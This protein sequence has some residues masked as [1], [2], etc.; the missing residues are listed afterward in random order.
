MSTLF[1]LADRNRICLNGRTPNDVQAGQWLTSFS[2][3]GDAHLRR[4]VNKFQRPSILQLNIEGLTASKMSVLHHLALQCEAL[5]ILL[6]ETHCTSVERLDIPSYH[7]AGFSLSRKHGLATFVHERLKWILIDQSPPTSE[8]EWV[9]VDVDNYKIVNMVRMIMELI[10]NRSFTLTTGDSK[11]SRLRRL[12]N[13]VLQGSVLA[14]LFFNI[15]TYD[16]P[17]ITSKKFAYADDL[18]ILYTSGEWKELERTLSQDMITLSEY[19]QTWRLKL[20]HTKTVTAAFHLHNREAKRELKVCNIGKT[21]PFCPVPTYLGVKLDRSL[22]YRPHLEALRKKL[23]AR[24]SLLRRLAGT[25]W[26]A[27]AK[28]LRTAALSLVYSTVEYCAPVWCRSVHIRLIDSVINDALRI[29]TGCLRPTPSVY[30]PVLSGIHP[31]ELRRQGA[32][33]SLANRSSQDPDYILHGQFHES[34]D[35]CRERLKSRRSF[36]LAARKLLDSLSEMDVRAAEWT[37]TKWDMEY[38]ANALS[39]HAFILKASS[40]PLGMGLPRA[41]WVK[42]N[43]LRS[44]V[45]RFCS[46][47][48]KWGLAPLENCECGAS[49]QTADHIISQCPIHRAPRGMFGLMVLDDETRCWLKSLTDN[50]D[51]CTAGVSNLFGRRATCN[52]RM[53][54]RAT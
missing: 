53:I 38:S 46:S 7:L 48:Y 36:V 9:C 31:A 41:A 45:G 30:L 17:S 29:V 13:G 3:R 51:S 18:A 16:I 40:R 44:G 54:A 15:C 2:G 42:L 49:E 23:C 1:N 47:M 19:L 5:V 22:T 27:S 32:T 10:R 25:G 52:F 33:L 4:T 50:D 20:S 21:L 26:G 12:R 39:L 37:N 34:Q 43:H 11:P 14:S 28:T 35:I 6:Q 24:V 8:I